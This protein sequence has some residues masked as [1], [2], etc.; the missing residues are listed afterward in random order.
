MR[1]ER[2]TATAFDSA[3]SRIE[4][5]EIIT[6]A[7]LLP[8]SWENHKN[9]RSVSNAITIIIDS[10]DS[11]F[12]IGIVLYRCHFRHIYAGAVKEEREISHRPHVLRLTLKESSRSSVHDPIMEGLLGIVN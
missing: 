2:G 12:D 4:Q 1:R 7:S 5:I 6:G 3:P 8:L 9:W 10:A 11:D